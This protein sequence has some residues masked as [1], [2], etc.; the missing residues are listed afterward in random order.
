M[1]TVVAGTGRVFRASDSSRRGFEER[2]SLYRHDRLRSRWAGCAECGG[3]DLDRPRVVDSLNGV[4]GICATCG[5]CYSC[6][7][8]GAIHTVDFAPPG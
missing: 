1:E 2:M 4:D 5:R 3:R 6:D 7:Q 8:A